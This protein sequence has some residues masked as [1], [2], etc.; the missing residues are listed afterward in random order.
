ML[1]V[2]NSLTSITEKLNFKCV[3]DKILYDIVSSIIYPISIIGFFIYHSEYSSG[4][5]HHLGTSRSWYSSF[6]FI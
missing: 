5:H 4:P 2:S 1:L 6:L 3:P